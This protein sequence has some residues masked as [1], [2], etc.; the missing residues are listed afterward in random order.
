MPARRPMTACGAGRRGHARRGAHAHAGRR[1]RLRPGGAA[2]ARGACVRG[3]AEGAP[4]GQYTMPMASRTSPK[5]S[6]AISFA[7]RLPSWMTSLM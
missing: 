3:A 4:R 1:L 5:V 7:R 6:L 2:V